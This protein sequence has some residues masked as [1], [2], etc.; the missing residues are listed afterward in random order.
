[1]LDSEIATSTALVHEPSD[2][3]SAT[4][5]GPGTYTAF[6]CQARTH[7]DGLVNFR[8]EDVP[9]TPKNV[10]CSN[11]VGSYLAGG[12]YYEPRVLDTL[13]RYYKFQIPGPSAR[14]ANLYYYSPDSTGGRVTLSIRSV[15]NDPATEVARGAFS[16]WAEGRPCADS[17][18]S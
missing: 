5:Q 3:V 6:R 10:D 7:D 4:V 13:P 2:Y 8:I 18:P 11:A 15:C 9:P 17:A 16:L 14:S 12:V 1:L